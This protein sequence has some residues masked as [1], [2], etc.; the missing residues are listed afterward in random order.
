MAN[1]RAAPIFRFNDQRA[2]LVRKTV[3]RVCE[4]TGD[5]LLALNDAAYHETRR[6]DGS[7]RPREQERLESWKSLARRLSRMT[8]GERELALRELAHEYAED[9]AGNFDPRVFSFSTRLVP[10]LVTGL[11]NP[12]SLARSISDPASLFS[13]GSLRDKVRVE[14]DIA[15]L[16][17]LAE[18]GTLVFVPTHSSN[19]DSLAIGESL[20]RKDLPP[21]VY[22]AGKN[23]F[24]NPLLSFFNRWFELSEQFFEL[25]QRLHSLQR[26]A[27]F[28]QLLL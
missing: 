18:I 27:L 9:I 16:Q 7:K 12:S 3:D 15:Q 4:V 22:G 25:A 26:L 20:A 19:L 17:R 21:V 1:T 10:T 28:L 5:P 8:Q 13:I 2:S 11:L 24:T 14:G 6:L 23:L